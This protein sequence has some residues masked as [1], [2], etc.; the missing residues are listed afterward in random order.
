[1]CGYSH[2]ASNLPVGA[3]EEPEKDEGDD[4]D[5]NWR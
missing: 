2:P 5:G 4:D 3:E 1:M